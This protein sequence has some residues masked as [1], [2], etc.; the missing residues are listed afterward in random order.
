MVSRTLYG[1]QLEDY[2]IR[3]HPAEPQGLEEGTNG[4]QDLVWEPT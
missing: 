1:Y 3:E 4:E 2:L